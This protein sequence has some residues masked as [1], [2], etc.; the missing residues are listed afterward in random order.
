M[1]TTQRDELLVA[2]AHQR[3]PDPDA[4]LRLCAAALLAVVAPEVCP[5]PMPQLQSC[6]A[7]GLCGAF[8][9]LLLEVPLDDVRLQFLSLS[10]PEGVARWCE[11]APSMVAEAAY[12]AHAAFFDPELPA[13]PGPGDRPRPLPRNDQ[14]HNDAQLAFYVFRAVADQE[15]PGLLALRSAGSDALGTTQNRAR[16]AELTELAYAFATVA[17]ADTTTPLDLFVRIWPEEVVALFEAPGSTEA[18]AATAAVLRALRAAV[19][20]MATDPAPVGAGASE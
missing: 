10:D 17:N 3:R 9:T 15:P 19:A 18:Y 1:T 12:A 6:D 16:R 5:L 7:E 14:V 20:G 11:R 2:L 8:A 4:V 13:R